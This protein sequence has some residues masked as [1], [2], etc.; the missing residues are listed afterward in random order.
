MSE[1]IKINTISNYLE[2]LKNDLDIYNLINGKQRLLLSKHE[3]EIIKNFIGPTELV[4]D[5]K[6]SNMFLFIN[7][8]FEQ[9]ST[10]TD[11]NPNQKQ[12]YKEYVNAYIS[13][14]MKNDISRVYTDD[15]LK[16]A[17]SNYIVIDNEYK[18]LPTIIKRYNFIKNKN[19]LNISEIYNNYKYNIYNQST[20]YQKIYKNKKHDNL[21]F[22]IKNKLKELLINEIF[23]LIFKNI[24]KYI[25]YIFY[26]IFLIVQNYLIDTNLD[27]YNNI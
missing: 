5:Y 8:Q 13:D 21:K 12:L 25:S 26:N 15:V 14:Y 7:H 4:Y 27:I 19:Q 16:V 22:K 9:I 20:F 3:R 18:L 10:L 6:I 1:S 24:K 11:L 23:H 17:I 2:L